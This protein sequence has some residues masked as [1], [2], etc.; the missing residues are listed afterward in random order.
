MGFRRVLYAL[1]LIILIARTSFVFGVFF[2]Y[3]SSPQDIQSQSFFDSLR[4]K[5]TQR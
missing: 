1:I 2:D 4:E 3:K 5:F